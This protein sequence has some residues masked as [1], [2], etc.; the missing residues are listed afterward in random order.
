LSNL[1]DQ[2]VTDQPAWVKP[3]LAA[4]RKGHSVTKAAKT[5]KIVR[6]TAY[7]HRD[8]NPEFKAVWQEAI[9][10]SVEALEDIARERAVDHSD[11]L[12]IFLLKARKPELYRENLK[13]EGHVTVNH[14]SDLSDDEL[15]RIASRGSTGTPS[16]A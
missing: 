16:E 3:F 4:L 1:D 9:D 7:A 6:Q 15:I 12:L 5:A 8:I 11:T 13:V 2:K 10:E 14:V